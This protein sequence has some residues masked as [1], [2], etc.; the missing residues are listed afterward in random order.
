MKN[1]WGGILVKKT[2]KTMLTAAILTAAMSFTSCDPTGSDVQDVYG[3]P[4]VTETTEADTT[5]PTTAEPTTT[6]DASKETA[7]PVYGP[8]V[9]TEDERQTTTITT[10]T[11]P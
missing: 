5:E 8:P 1:K 9:T 3:P 6:Y 10:T 11:T 4:V 7:Q 2:K